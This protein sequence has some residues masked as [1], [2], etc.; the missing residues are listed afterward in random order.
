[1]KHGYTKRF[2]V[3][4]VAG[5]SVLGML[6]PP[7]LLLIVYGLVAEASVG[8]LFIAAIIPGIILS[9]AFGLAIYRDDLF[10]AALR[11]QR[12]SGRRPCRSVTW[13]QIGGQLVPIAVLVCAVVGGIYGGLFTPTEAAAV[14][15]AFAFVLALVKRRIGWTEFR[16]IVLE[17]SFVSAAI[18]FLIVAANL[19]TRQVALTGIPMHG[20]GL[21][22]DRRPRHG[23]VPGGLFRDP[24]AA[25]HDPR[26][27][28][29][30]C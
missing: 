22:D 20:L 23:D 6:I 30:S 29:R 4:T 12:A 3:G 27:R 26:T 9:V 5:S 11:R 18:L 16:A 21:G 19:Y 15:T 8:R 14:G 7:S 25:R 2:S 1:M 10:H 13:A 24:A 28:C 17:T